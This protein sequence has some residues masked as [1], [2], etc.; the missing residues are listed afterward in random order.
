MFILRGLTL[1]PLQRRPGLAPF[2]SDVAGDA[3]DSMAED[4]MMNA[5]GPRGSI[6]SIGYEGFTVDALVRRLVSA[7]V[8]VLYD[9]RLN[10]VSRRPGF[11]KRALTATWV[12]PSSW[13]STGSS[14]VTMFL[15]DVL[16]ELRTA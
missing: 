3:H 11:S 2:E 16:R 10:A 15:S 7:R 8:T 9:V 1:E 4:A 12:T 14:M 5:V 6:F 13:Y